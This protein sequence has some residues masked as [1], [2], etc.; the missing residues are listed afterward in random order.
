M[1]KCDKRLRTLTFNVI[2]RSSKSWR[3]GRLKVTTLHNTLSLSI[4]LVKC[5]GDSKMLQVQDLHRQSQYW[6]PFWALLTRS[7]LACDWCQ[8]I[9]SPECSAR[10]VCTGKIP[11]HCRTTSV[12]RLI[13]HWN[14][15][16]S[17]V[18]HLIPPL[19]GWAWWWAWRLTSPPYCSDTVRPSGPFG[20]C[21]NSV[22]GILKSSK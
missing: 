9:A 19:R 4:S 8:S 21:H 1:K 20:K 11:Y 2:F 13:S 3:S 6:F 16:Y 17:A 5:Q 18:S 14:Y 10:K 12:R 22:Q 7:R 15:R